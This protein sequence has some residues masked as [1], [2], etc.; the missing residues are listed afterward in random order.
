MKST[1][2]TNSKPKRTYP[3]LGISTSPT[4]AGLIVL[5][6]KPDT[7]MVVQSGTSCHVLGAYANNWADVG[8]DCFKLLAGKVTLEN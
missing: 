5:F 8:C 2:S 1:V 7:G 3:Y 4:S 6:T